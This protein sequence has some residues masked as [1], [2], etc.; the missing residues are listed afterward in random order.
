[1]VPQNKSVWCFLANLIVPAGLCLSAQTTVTVSAQANPWLAG[2]PVGTAIPDPHGVTPPDIVPDQAPVLVPLVLD[3]DVQVLAVTGATWN[4]PAP[5]TP[6]GP[7][8]DTTT[9]FS[10][11]AGDYYFGKS[12]VYAPFMSLVGVFLDDAIPAGDPP[13]T[14]EF[15]TQQ[16]RDYLVLSPLLRQVF[17][18]GDGRTSGGAQQ[19]I[20]VPAGATR[21]YLG[22]MDAYQWW[23][24]AGSLSVTVA[25]VP[26]PASILFASS[27]LL[28]GTRRRRIKLW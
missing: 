13:P 21:L 19:Q 27:L 17:F 8:G 10:F 15:F 9:F 24:N 7:E 11:Q 5:V 23:G 18:I 4:G 16:S 12:D 2:M 20:G 1:M 26:E 14:L 22:V 3:N 28:V 6:V 25:V